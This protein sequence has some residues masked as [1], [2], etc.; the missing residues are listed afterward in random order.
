MARTGRYKLMMMLGGLCAVAGPLGM[1]FWTRGKTSEAG[2]WLTMPWG[3]AGYGSILTITLVA[4][5][6]AIDP[7]DMAAATGVTYLFR[8][9]GSV[10]GIS[11]SNAILQNSLQANL[12]SAGIPKKV[13]RAIRSDVSAIRSLDKHT[14]ELA[15]G[16][17]Q[18]AMRTVFIA[19]TVAA[20]AAFISLI[21]IRE[22]SL[23]GSKKPGPPHAPA[24]ASTS[25]ESAI[26]EEDEDEQ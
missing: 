9:T 7:K 10:L 20:L 6:A 1:C 2:Y 11:L 16:A 3:G 4:L 25:R 17:Y 18:S 22:H 24:A 8:A 23:P 21:P 5:I 26:A 15:I 19:I 14:K 13:A 12:A